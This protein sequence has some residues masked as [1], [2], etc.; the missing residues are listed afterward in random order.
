MKPIVTAVAAI[1]LLSLTACSTAA[2]KVMANALSAGGPSSRAFASDDDP[3][4]VK[5]AVPFGLKTMESVLEE[6]PRHVGLLTSLVAGFTQY[7]YAFVQ[8]D[9]DAA[10][11]DGKTA[12][13]RAGRDRAR[14]L[15][16]RARDYGLRGLDARHHGLAARI[17]AMKD[18]PAV[19]QE[20]EREDVPLLYW[21]AAS[22]ALAISD[23]KEQMDLVAELP[24]PQALADRALA[25]DEGWGDGAVH[26]FFVSFD[27]AL[28]AA[29]GG[30]AKAA[31]AHLER[32]LELSHGEK[33]GGL[34][35]YAEG[36]SV[37]VQD[38]REFEALLK[39][40]V[41]F[42]AEDHPRFR[43]ANL[44]AQRRAK[45]LLAHEDDLFP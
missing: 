15:Y 34:V 11:L 35:A 7:S 23:G 41:D 12:L 10:E 5:D 8:S 38:R 33:L 2:S 44:L 42:D 24:A 43:L 6:Q 27:A 18:L 16:L 30:G 3:E 9:A 4:L 13:A 32:A 19:L 17:Q 14:R 28:P 45:L 25:L 39:Q 20:A 22:W 37:Q 29:A 31:R 36:I 1:W 21:T 26:E 40:V